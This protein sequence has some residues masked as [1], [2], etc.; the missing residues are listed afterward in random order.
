[1]ALPTTE[2]LIAWMQRQGLK[3]VDLA[4]KMQISE[5]SVSLILNGHRDPTDAFA[6]R[7]AMTFPPADFAEVFGSNGHAQPTEAVA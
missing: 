2:R 4:R 6:G 1:M 7:F 5:S 3:Q